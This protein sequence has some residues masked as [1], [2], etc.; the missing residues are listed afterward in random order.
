MTAL[1]QL[2]NVA[3]R[4]EPSARLWAMRTLADALELSVTELYLTKLH[5]DPT[6]DT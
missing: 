6:T 1:S 3:D 2:E 4:H 5:V